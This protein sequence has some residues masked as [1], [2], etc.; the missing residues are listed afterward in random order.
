MTR[1]EILEQI[2][3]NLD[4]AIQYCLHHEV[5]M[6]VLR[7]LGA[8]DLD[9][10]GVEIFLASMPTTPT[11]VLDQLI[12]R[13][14]HE[15][16][17]L[18]SQKPALHSK[19][20]AHPDPVVRQQVAE[21]RHIAPNIAQQLARDEAVAV[22]VALAKNPV[23]LTNV[24]HVLLADPVPFVRLALLENRRLEPEFMDGLSDDMNPTVHACTLLSPK[25]SPVCMKSWAEFDEELGQLALAHRN[26]L[27]PAIVNLL[28]QSKYPSVQQA[29]LRQPSLPE[30]FL[31]AQAVSED[32]AVLHIIV[33]RKHLSADLQRS[34]IANPALSLDS[35]RAMA[36]RADLT[37]EVGTALCDT[38]DLKLLRH[39]AVNLAPQLSATRMRLTTCGSPLILKLLLVIPTAHTPEVLS[40]L[41]LHATE[42]V[43]SHLAYRSISCEA[44]LPEAQE[45]L[46]N[47]VLPSVREL[48]GAV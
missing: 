46:R 15:V 22:R 27:P 35:K 45:R 14:N 24:Q 16:T 11:G 1:E 12:Q 10:P 28:S 41:V 40:S 21:N 25:L 44:L 23:I 7:E 42:D 38:G 4:D 18:L 5:G 3:I 43:L 37:D 31:A 19:L 8:T 34:L 6:G 17:R 26:D 36:Q 9:T 39:L 20:S 2:S 13:G 32:S 47:C 48:V 29:L 30:E 33:N